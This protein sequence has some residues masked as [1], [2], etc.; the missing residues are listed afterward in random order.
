VPEPEKNFLLSPPGSPPVDWRQER[1]QSPHSGGHSALF[2]DLSF[3]SFSLEPGQESSTRKMETDSPDGQDQSMERMVKESLSPDGTRMVLS[4]TRTSLPQP[5]SSRS[6]NKSLKMEESQFSSSSLDED[7]SLS[8]SASVESLPMI[9][10]ENVDG[11]PL[12][13][14]GDSGLTLP[15]TALPKTSAPACFLMDD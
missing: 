10:V 11:D 14:W 5:Q 12:Q 1:E 3:E 13:T 15:T 6:A 7:A 9:V 8:Q 2:S 4:F